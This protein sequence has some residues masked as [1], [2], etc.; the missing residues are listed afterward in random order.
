M[1]KE[2][3]CKSCG[4]PL[5]EFKP[6]SIR[7]EG[8]CPYCVDKQGNLKAYDK[9]LKGM[10]SY[11][12]HDHPE[13][14][15][16]QMEEK[17][18]EWLHE[19]EVWKQVFKG[20]IIEE[21]LENK[22]VLKLCKIVSTKIENDANPKT[23]GGETK[24][25][26]RQVEV[27]RSDLDEVVKLLKKNLKRPNWWADFS[28]ENEVYIVFRRKAFTGNKNDKEFVKN[29]REFGKTKGLP[30]EQIPL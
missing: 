24:W 28:F 16:N 3:V 18:V 17:A 7:K 27:L 26:I 30:E 11:I 10:L 21:S 14:K 29:V 1:S 25:T 20:F 8:F 4:G 15:E 5:F 23:N 13:I 19:A 9:V 22:D 6:E 2:Q 12:K